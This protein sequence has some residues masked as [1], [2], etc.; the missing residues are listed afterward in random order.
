MVRNFSQ[1]E[2]VCSCNYMDRWTIKQMWN[3]VEL[4]IVDKWNNIVHNFASKVLCSFIYI[5]EEYESDLSQ[6]CENAE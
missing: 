3:G 1:W 6:L 4:T 2:D 5:Y